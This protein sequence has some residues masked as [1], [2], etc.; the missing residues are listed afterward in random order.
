MKN[1]ESQWGRIKDAQRVVPA[2]RSCF[3]NWINAGYVISRR[4]GGARY[5]DLN[6]VRNLL[7][8]APLS[9]DAELQHEMKRRAALAV[10]ARRKKIGAGE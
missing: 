5:I 8:S 7:A 6:S 2:S 4:M 1:T 3:Y 9:A 10:A